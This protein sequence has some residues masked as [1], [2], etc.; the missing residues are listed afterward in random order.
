M[1]AVKRAEEIDT[2]DALQDIERCAVEVTAQRQTGRRDENIEPAERLD[3]G[4]N[5]SLALSGL[6]DV[7]CDGPGLTAVLGNRAIARL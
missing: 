7:G 3:R 5:G 6:G 1:S 2:H 4:G